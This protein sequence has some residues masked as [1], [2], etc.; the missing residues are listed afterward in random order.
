MSGR[1][2]LDRPLRG[3]TKLQRADS[4]RHHRSM[5]LQHL[6]AEGPASRADLARSSGLTR[7]TVSDLVAELLEERL[8]AELGAPVESRVGKPPTLVGL[9]PDA[10]HVVA[11]DL[12]VDD[13]VA[14]AVLTLTGEVVSRDARP[15]GGLRGAD[16]VA[17]VRDFAAGLTAWSSPPRTWSGTTS[18]S[19]R[20]WR[21]RWT[22][23]STSRTTPTPP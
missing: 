12:S 1:N 10:K 21:R 23:P 8:V 6:F 3:R 20:R 15:L 18:R 16:A 2:P 22:F 14:G 11:V 17:L 9:V 7:V 4:R 19:P 5:L 13:Q